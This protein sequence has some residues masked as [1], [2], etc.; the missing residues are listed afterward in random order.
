MRIKRFINRIGR[1]NFSKKREDGAGFHK[2]KVKCYKCHKFGHFARECRGSVVQQSNPSNYNRN[3]QGNS[4]QALVSQEGQGF[5]WSDQAEEGVHDQ[6][7]IAEIL[8]DAEIPAVK[9]CTEH[10]QGMCANLKR[11][12]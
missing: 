5:D 2:T 1:K 12:E 11:L 8:D 7:L 9:K 6:A 4:S 3:T 10:N